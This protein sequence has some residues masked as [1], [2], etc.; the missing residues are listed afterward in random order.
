M[1]FIL[2]M[3]SPDKPNPLSERR[4][5]DGTAVDLVRLRTPYVGPSCI[6]EEN[7]K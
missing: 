4:R 3:E 7:N 2:T 1:N 6:K 5:V